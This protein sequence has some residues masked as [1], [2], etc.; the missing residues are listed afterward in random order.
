MKFVQFQAT[1]SEPTMWNELN[2]LTMVHDKKTNKQ[3]ALKKARK[4]RKLWQ[5]KIV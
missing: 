2:T 4:K 1:N 3:Q 5:A